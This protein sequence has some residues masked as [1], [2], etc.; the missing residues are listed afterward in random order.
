[1]LV[2]SG[3][4]SMFHA[5]MSASEMFLPRP[6]VSA[7]AT[8]PNA[9]ESARER[10]SLCVDM[11]DLP[12]VVD[13]PAG[14]AVVVLVR[15][16]QWVGHRPLGLAARG[17]EFGPGRLCVAGLVPGAAEQDP[18]LAVPAPRDGEAREGLRVDRPLQGGLRP[19]LAAIGRDHDFG[20]AAG[21]WIGD[22]R[23][24]VVARPLERVTERRMRDERLH[25][26][27][28]VELHE[29]LARHD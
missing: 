18:G 15:E 10:T 20:D 9:T 14:E 8:D 1:M 25:L 12:F 4:T 28:E 26:H 19:A 27:D 13:G 2:P 5:L 21:A 16:S 17:D 3:R 24:F 29:L 23:Y 11:F 22:T 6:G 7:S